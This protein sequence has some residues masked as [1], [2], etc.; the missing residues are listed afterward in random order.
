MKK[1]N[2]ISHTAN[3]ISH[4]RLG[5]EINVTPEPLWKLV[6]VDVSCKH[7]MLVDDEFVINKL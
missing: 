1:T 3:N 2:I 7:K 4:S 6:I 5:V